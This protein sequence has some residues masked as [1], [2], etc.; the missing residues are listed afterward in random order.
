MKP[1]KIFLY[2]YMVSLAGVVLF[3]S[4]DYETLMLY[5]RACSIPTIF[6]YYLITKK[7]KIEWIKFFIFLFCFIGDIYLIAGFKKY[8]TIGGMVVNLCAYLLLLYLVVKDFKRIKFDKGKSLQFLLIFVFLLYLLISVLTLKLEK[9]P[10][11][12]SLYAF[13]GSILIVLSFFSIA[14]Y[15]TR[16]CYTFLNLVFMASCFIVADMFFA[17]NFYYFP[18]KI[19]FLIVVTSQV[20]A[21]FF[22]VH[23][24]LLN[25]AHIE[26]HP[27][28]GDSND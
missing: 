4:F 3:Q 26:N 10:A 23:Y 24:F 22:M 11:D 20:A 16:P 18:L 25:E 28:S 14:N 5:S 6:T 17:L 9:L 12:I 15:V 8:F 13:Y 19:F 27:V 2:L 1:N 7:F 21:Y